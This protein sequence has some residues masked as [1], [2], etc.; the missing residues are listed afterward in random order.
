MILH[1]T[2]HGAGPPVLLL[3]GLYGA[4]QNLGMI[5]RALADYRVIALDLRNHGAS[6]HAPDMRYASMAQDVIDTMDALGLDDAVL[7]GHSMGGKTAMMAALTYGVRVRALAVLDI[8]PIALDH[9]ETSAAIIDALAAIKLTP[10][11]TRQRADADLAATIADP[12]LRGFLLNNLRIS[13]GS[14][15]YWRLDLPAIRAALPDL[16]GWVD[17]QNLQPYLGPTL[18]VRGGESDY[19]PRAAQAEIM[20]RFPRATIETIDHAGHWLHAEQPL[21]VNAALRR[22]FALVPNRADA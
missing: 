17:P 9:I 7:I 10:D 3:H 11:L 22:L 2:D 13:S 19:V 14:A 20:E 4:G 6:P 16:T 12:A 1:C 8:A 5:A 15:P 21:A 18:V